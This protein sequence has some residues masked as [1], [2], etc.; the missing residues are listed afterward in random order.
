MGLLSADN[1]RDTALAWL[2]VAVQFALLV[3]IV[4]LPPSDAWPVPAWL[5][6]VGFALEVAGAVVLLV[7]IVNLGRSLT[8]LPTPVPHGELR[9]GGLYRWVR[10]PIHAGIIALVVGVT[11]RSAS[12]AVALATGAL[13]VWFM[14][15]ARWEE[16]HLMQRYAGYTAYVAHTPR[17]VPFW[18]TGQPSS[19]LTQG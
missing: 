3:V 6:T 19:D 18:P 11:L 15:K 10:H 8:P 5:A 17:F 13:I 9:V 1:P 16:Q 14:L 4:L 2:F 12:L 7:A